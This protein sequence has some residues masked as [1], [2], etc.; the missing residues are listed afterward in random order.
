MK[1][2]LI[3][4]STQIL[5]V[6]LCAF[7]LLFTLML[8]RDLGSSM[9]NYQRQHDGNLLVSQASNAQMQDIVH[10]ADNRGISIRQNKPFMYGKLISI[11]GQ[12]LADFSQNPVTA[13][14]PYNGKFDCIGVMKFLQIMNCYR[15][16]GGPPMR[17]AGSKYRWNRRY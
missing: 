6:G 16:N 15:D 1:Q 12:S 17:K 3:T 10:W 5:G 13:W 14:P 9:A 8:L 2:R 4:K 7:L 11:N